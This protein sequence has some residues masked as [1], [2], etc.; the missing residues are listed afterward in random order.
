VR[1]AC[2]IKQDQLKTALRA[3]H[4]EFD[5]AHLERKEVNAD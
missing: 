4:H 2:I 1:I 5:L 3:I